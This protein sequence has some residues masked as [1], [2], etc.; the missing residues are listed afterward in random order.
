MQAS[1]EKKR[2][3]FPIDSAMASMDGSSCAPRDFAFQEGYSGISIENGAA[4]VVDLQKL[5]PSEIWEPLV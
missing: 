5:Q 4:V 1:K 2:A 3:L